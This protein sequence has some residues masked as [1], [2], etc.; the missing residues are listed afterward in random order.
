MS[1]FCRV[2]HFKTILIQLTENKICLLV[3][4]KK[5]KIRQASA[6]KTFYF[7]FLSFF[8]NN[9]LC[10]PE[11]HTKNKAYLPMSFIISSLLEHE[12]M[13]YYGLVFLQIFYCFDKAKWYLERHAHIVHCVGN[14]TW[15]VILKAAQGHSLHVCMYVSFVC[16]V[17]Q[18]VGTPC[19]PQLAVFCCSK[20]LL[21]LYHSSP[22]FCHPFIFYS[23]SPS[24]IL[25]LSIYPVSI[26]FF[27]S[28][29]FFLL[30][31]VF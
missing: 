24:S 18:D 8:Y 26:R 12:L 21:T 2:F 15:V 16:Q 25:L 22:L 31:Y 5:I 14:S 19:Y 23:H 9:C 4:K 30:P 17:F 11:F 1:I 3:E 7:F 29:F 13:K 20:K 27:M 28:F 10:I 6:F